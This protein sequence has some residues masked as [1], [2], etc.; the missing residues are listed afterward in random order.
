M[1]LF[2]RLRA[3]FSKPALDADFAAEL[4]QHLEAATADNIRAGMTLVEAQRRARIA[5]GGVEQTRELHR[6]ARGLPWLENLARDVRFGFRSLRRSPGFSLAVLTT[7]A[8]CL[9][10]NTAILSVLYALVYKP[11]PFLEPERL[12]SIANVVEKTAGA[13]RPS[14]VGQYLDFK[15]HADRFESFGYFTTTNATIGDPDTPVRGVGIQVSAGFLSVLGLQPLLGRF[16]LPEEQKPGQEQVV[17]LSH[18]AWQRR[19]HG[20]PKV[21]GREMRLDDQAYTIVGVAPS[22]FEEIFTDVEFFRPYSV[23]PEETHPQ[24]RYAGTVR[25]IGRLKPGVTREAGHAQLAV[26][27]KAFYDTQ[28]G[29]PLRALLDKGGYRVAVVD[30]RQELAEAVK[31]PLLLLQL[32]AGLVLLIGCVNVASLLLARANAQR[33]ELTIRLALG[34]GRAALLRRML[35]ESLL[36]VGLAGAGGI[37]LALGMLQLMNHYLPMVVRHVPPVQLD[38]PVLGIVA[39]GVG[40]IILTMG[41]VPFAFLWRSGLNLRATPQASVGRRGRKALSALVVGQVAVALVLLIGAGLLIHS[42]ARVMAVRPGFDAAR[43]VQGRVNLPPARYRDPKA[44]LA[45]QQRILATMKEIPGVEAASLTTEFGVAASFRAVPFH[46]RRSDAAAGTAQSLVYLNSVSPDYFATMGIL[47]RDGRVFRDDDEARKNPVAIVDQSFVERY[48]P[49]RDIVGQELV[50]GGA[51]PPEGQPWIR[52]IGVVARANLSGREGRDGWPFIYL[53]FNQ[54]PT[55]GGL[56]VLI[57]SPRLESDLVGEMRVRLRSV[58]PAL[59]LFAAG[60]LESGLDSLL[61]TRRALMLLLGFFAGLAMLLAAVGL[62]GVLNYEVSQRAREIGIRGAVGATRGQIISL[63]LGQ[64]LRKAALGLATGM[65]GAVLF[66][67]FMGKLLFD[68]RPVEPLVFGAVAA[69]LLLIAFLAS[70]LPARRAAKVDPIVVLR[71]E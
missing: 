42:F 46:L 13:K 61:G 1:R 63:I 30:A 52:I 47:L 28:A 51:P 40:V 41:V 39:A 21:V 44:N 71:A 20:D 2:S 67:R 45:V 7:L 31:A 36:L 33:T 62:Y 66:T 19:Y 15:A 68:V 12:T 4:A 14:S 59:P 22:S 64:G 25:L 29:P 9:G 53:P 24:T 35:V 18:A 69:L 23:R 5:L 34:A 65:I 55:V 32:G 50:L 48:F 8:L 60:S 10:P 54:Q 70:W 56:S 11:L 27:E 57:R 16:F 38:L 58:D 26:L 17:V 49:G 43:V 6:D 3:V 37:G